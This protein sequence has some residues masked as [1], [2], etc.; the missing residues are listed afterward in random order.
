MKATQ[1]CPSS[2]LLCI[3]HFPIVSSYIVS[4]PLPS[5]HSFLSYIWL[6]SENSGKKWKKYFL[7]KR[8][9]RWLLAQLFVF[10]QGHCLQ[11]IS[12]F[13]ILSC[14]RISGEIN[15]RGADFS[16]RHSDSMALIGPGFVY[17]FIVCSAYLWLCNKPT[18]S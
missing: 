1:Y 11:M 17:F 12:S 2:F 8:S 3:K 7:I 5:S 16:A 6:F 14:N 13:S 18:Q 9:Q 10:V 15:Q 4:N